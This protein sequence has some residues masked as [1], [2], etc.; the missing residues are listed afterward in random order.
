MASAVVEEVVNRAG[1]KPKAIQDVVL[2]CAFP[3]SCQGMNVARIVV[4]R[5]GLPDGVPAMTINRFCSSGLEAI[6]IAAAK[7]RSGMYDIAIAGGVESMSLIPMGG[8]KISPNPYLADERPDVYTSMGNCGDNMARDFNITREQADEWALRSNQR[9]VAAIDQ[10][11][12]KEEIVPLEVPTGNGSTIVFDTD[13]GP[14]RDTSLEALAGLRPAFAASPKL[15]IQT[16]GNSS[17]TSDGAA[18]VCLMSRAGVKKTGATPIAKVLGYYAAAG[19]PKYLGP[20]QLVAIPKAL[21]QSKVKLE[22]V[23]LIEN[24]EAFASQ[25]L[26]VNREMKFDSEKVNVNGGA[27]ALGHPL[28]CTGTKL[29]VQIMHE[30]KRRGGKYGLVTMCIGGGMGAAGVFEMCE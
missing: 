17:Q 12:F 3:E 19:P 30:L 4:A 27:I 20:A 25:C 5:A 21:R 26:Y 14:R 1:V 16:A 9:A 6:H 23:D 2:G 28:G 10:E 13:E 15:G 11:K 18:A 22:D 29:S 8:F 24:N 7:I